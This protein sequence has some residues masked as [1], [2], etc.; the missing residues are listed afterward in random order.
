MPQIRVSAI[1]NRKRAIT[2]GTAVRLARYFG[3]SPEFW[4]GMHWMGMQMTYD[5]ETARYRP[6]EDIEA[7]VHP[8]TG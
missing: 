3:T 8:R 2:L 6:G 5:P 4:M 1:V 7:Q